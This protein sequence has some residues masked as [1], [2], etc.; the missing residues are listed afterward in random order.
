MASVSTDISLLLNK[1]S[2]AVGET[3]TASGT[4]A[5]NAWVP[6]KVVDAAQNIVLFDTTKADANGNYSIDIVIPAGASG[7]LTVI[8]GEGSNVATKSLTVT[9]TPPVDTEAPVWTDGSLIASNI[10]QTTLTL[11]W[12]GAT[13]NVGVTG[14]KVYQDGTL[15]TETPVS[16]TSYEVTGLSAG[17]EY[18]FKVEAEDAAGN[19][20]TD[21]PSITV[22]TKMEIVA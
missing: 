14:Y 18:T 5:P 8:A 13:D 3:V 21:G 22:S 11:S 9:E 12:S 7:T 17:T 4:A 15:L 19:E 1:T 20:R 6:L 10:T 16:G 2:A